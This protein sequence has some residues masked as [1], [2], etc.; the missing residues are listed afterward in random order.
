MDHEWEKFQK[1]IRA[2]QNLKPIRL[3]EINTKK[4]GHAVKSSKENFEHEENKP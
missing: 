1:T 4:V 2:A 3:P